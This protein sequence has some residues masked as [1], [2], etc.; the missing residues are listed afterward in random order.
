MGHLSITPALIAAIGLLSLLMAGCGGGESAQGN[1]NTSKSKT[2]I[3]LY[4]SY[5]D[6]SA[7]DLVARAKAMA[8]QI[9][10]GE[11]PEAQSTYNSA[12]VPYGHIE[13]VAES[14]GDL[15]S[16][17]DSLPGEVPA[18]ELS[19]FHRIEKTLWEEGTTKGMTQVA[20]QLLADVERLQDE[21]KTVRLQPAGVVQGAT[22][23]LGELSKTAIR[24]KEEP[25]AHIDL[26]DI[27]AAV[28]GAEGAFEGAKPPILEADPELVADIEANFEDAYSEGAG[29]KHFGIPAREPDQPF[30]EAAGTSFVLHEERT[31]AEFD[32]LD[33]K[34]DAIS[35]G[36][37]QAQELI[38]EG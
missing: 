18:N 19:G 28:E 16:R 3:A 2:A 17:I 27:S 8:G 23:S 5:L 22:E 24:G 4:R 38:G 31:E 14:F 35:E 12:R 37:S 32:A 15:D 13:P 21:V 26:V 30:P 6:K 25:Y 29:L 20:K 10:A 7:A 11:L 1:P 34:I 9:E 33:R 36:L